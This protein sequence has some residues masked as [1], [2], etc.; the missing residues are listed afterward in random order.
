MIINQIYYINCVLL[1]V[2]YKWFYNIILAT[3][4]FLALFRG[5]VKTQVLTT[6]LCYN[7]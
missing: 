7:L 3:P 1:T 4:G 5:W 6:V 2:A